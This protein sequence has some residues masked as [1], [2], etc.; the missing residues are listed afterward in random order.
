[1]APIGT[2]RGSLLV[3]LMWT[4]WHFNPTWDGL[5][6]HLEEL[7]PVAVVISFFLVFLTRRTGAVL[8][9]AAVHEWLDIGGAYSGYRRWAALAAVPFW[10][11]MAKKWPRKSKPD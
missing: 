3:A 10:L 6:S 7:F 5:I 9:A 2:I 8:L 11:W 4:A 1:V